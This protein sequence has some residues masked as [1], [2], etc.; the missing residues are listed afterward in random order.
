[1]K[2]QGCFTHRP[3]KNDFCLDVLFFTFLFWDLFLSFDLRQIRN[4]EYFIPAHDG[5]IFWPL[6]FGTG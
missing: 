1:M 4:G 6:G 3:K 2:I 5:S